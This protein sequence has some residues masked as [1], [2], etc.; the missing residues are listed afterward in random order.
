MVSMAIVL[1]CSRVRPGVFSRSSKASHSMGTRPNRPRRSC[2]II[3]VFHRRRFSS[4]TLGAGREEDD[5]EVELSERAGCDQQVVG[6]WPGGRPP[7]QRT[8][9]QPPLV[10]AYRIHSIHDLR[11]CV[12]VCMCTCFFRRCVRLPTDKP[13]QLSS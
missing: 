9:S 3:E 7:G 2:D 8:G 11:M 13:A 12:R 10:T 4:A 5:S 6:V 1:L